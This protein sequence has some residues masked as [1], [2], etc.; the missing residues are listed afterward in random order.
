MPATVRLNDIVDA[1]E[2]QFDESCSLLHR[3]TGQVETVSHV[4]LLEAEDLTTM[5]Y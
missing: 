5:L 1:Q 2:M 3:D 4:L